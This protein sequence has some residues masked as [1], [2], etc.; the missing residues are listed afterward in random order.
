MG[1]DTKDMFFWAAPCYSSATQQ[2]LLIVSFSPASLVA[3]AL[4]T[5]IQK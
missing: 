4:G 2:Q 5:T 3:M 1:I